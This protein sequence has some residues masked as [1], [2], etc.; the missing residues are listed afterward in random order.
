[1]RTDVE[2][3]LPDSRFAL[4]LAPESAKKKG[5]YT[6][7]EM[8]MLATHQC[9]YGQ[10]PLPLDT[11]AFTTFHAHSSLHRAAFTPRA[12]FTRRSFYTETLLH[13]AV[14]AQRPFHR[15]AST[16]RIFFTQTPLPGEALTQ[17]SFYIQKPFEHRGFYTRKL[18]A[19][20]HRKAFTQKIFTYRRA[21]RLLHTKQFLHK[22]AFTHRSSDT[23]KIQHRS[24]CR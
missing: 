16:H 12:T 9:C 11:K 17:S 24:V 20:L 5:E 21:E 22:D 13:T 15:G 6:L 14:F 18:F 8:Q 4:E 7:A 2:K 1:M 10:T 23:E 3:P 19:P